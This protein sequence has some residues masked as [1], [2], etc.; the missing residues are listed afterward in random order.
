MNQTKVSI[1]PVL[2]CVAAASVVLL[3]IVLLVG[4]KREIDV[5]SETDIAGREHEA[6]VPA[7]KQS[8]P[9][10]RSRSSADGDLGPTKRTGRANDGQ[11]RI[12]VVDVNSRPLQGAS[13]SIRS[14]AIGKRL[15]G[16]KTTSLTDLDG[17]ASFDAHG[18]IEIEIKLTGWAGLVDYV[19]VEPGPSVLRYVLSRG[20][21]VSGIVTDEGGKPLQGVTISSSGETTHH[22]GR[23]MSDL[24]GSYSV[25]GL[26]AGPIQLTASG[27]MGRAHA[28]VALSPDE[29]YIWNPMLIRSPSIRVRV[30]T[31]DGSAL[32]SCVVRLLRLIDTSAKEVSS[33]KL[34]DNDECTF[35]RVLPGDYFVDATPDGL[36]PVAARAR[37]SADVPHQEVLLVVGKAPLKGLLGHVKS[38]RST[39]ETVRRHDSGSTLVE[40]LAPGSG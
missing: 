21:V 26:P 31:A 32:P 36:N 22:R 1:A 8:T 16:P 17:H 20:G 27:G 18:R 5:P 13:V 14:K 40:D 6:V 3:S 7:P 34:R 12:E 37:V 39:F 24:D 9:A 33:R 15:R 29:H 35:Y 11:L 28:A 30:S 10:P 19:I 38:H 4:T 23:C 25:P 2:L